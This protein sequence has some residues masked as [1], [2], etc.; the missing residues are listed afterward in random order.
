MFS[1]RKTLFVTFPV[2]F[3]K[4]GKREERWEGRLTGRCMTV[5]YERYRTLLFTRNKQL[6]QLLSS[7]IVSPPSTFSTEMETTAFANYTCMLSCVEASHF[8]AQMP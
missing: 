8:H 1:F 6:L 5:K 4:N 2:V 3:Y 7:E